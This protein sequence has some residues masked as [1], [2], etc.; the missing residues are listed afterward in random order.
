MDETLPYGFS[1]AGVQKAGTSTLSQTLD[2]HP[3][4]SRAPRKELQFFTRED[5]DWSA[6]PYDDYRCPQRKPGQVLAGDAT[7]AYLWWPHALER[8]HAYR[9][10]LRLIVIFRD[11]IERAFS[12]WTMMRQRHP[13]TP[14]WPELISTFR[15]RTLPTEV[16]AGVT[17]MRFKHWS[18]VARG[19]YAEQLDRGFALFPRE[20]WLVLEFRSMLADFSPTVD[21]VTDF[22]EIDR[23]RA[24]PPLRRTLAGPEIVAGTA[25]MGQDLQTLAEL[26]ADDLGRLPAL[27]GLS[28]EAWPTQQILDGRLDPAE[29]ADRFAAKVTGRARR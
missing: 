19:Y 27:S 15:P 2:R 25:P 28:V 8:M 7:P 23:F 10:Q 29:L 17:P 24:V 3:Q 4:I 6:P 5:V 9:P 14:D 26:Y 22:L 12:H 18:A 21:R 11:P 20:Q 13:Q 1:I 16:P